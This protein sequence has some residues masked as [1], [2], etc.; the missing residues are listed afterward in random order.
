MPFELKNDTAK[1]QRA[2]DVILASLSLHLTLIYFCDIAI[3]SKAPQDY[4]EQ[5]WCVLRLLY[6]DK[7]TLELKK[8]KLFAKSIEYLG[9]VT[10]SGNPEHAE[11]ST[12]PVE[13]LEKLTTE[14]KWRSFLELCSVFRRFSLSFARLAALL[15]KKVRKPS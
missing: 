11:H 3:F 9:H 1:F 7:V 8:Y 12:D 6:E 5:I 2:I 13:K 15:K 14:T 4:I 10:R